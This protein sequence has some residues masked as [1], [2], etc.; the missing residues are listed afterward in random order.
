MMSYG[1]FETLYHVIASV[2]TKPLFEEAVYTSKHSSYIK[3]VGTEEN[4]YN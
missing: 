3:K 2:D 4:K 1:N